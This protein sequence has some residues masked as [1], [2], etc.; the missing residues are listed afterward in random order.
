MKGL[1]L[2]PL[3]WAFH[4][5]A[6]YIFA[7]VFCAE[8]GSL[9]SAGEIRLFTFVVTAV[10]LSIVLWQFI[11]GLQGHLTGS[12]SPPHD[13]GT[14]GDRHRFLGLAQLLVSG[15]TLLAITYTA[16]AVFLF[17]SCE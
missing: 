11:K 5:L 17:R 4:F 10:A 9:A 14:V 8:N 12:Q 7:A 15:L 2:S 1:Y 6:V 3:I 16:Y 13:Q